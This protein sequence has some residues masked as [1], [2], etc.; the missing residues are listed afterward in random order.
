MKFDPTDYFL[1]SAGNR[2]DDERRICYVR[3]EE[4]CVTCETVTKW[5][6]DAFEAMGVKQKPSIIRESDKSTKGSGGSE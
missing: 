2:S 6:Y 3:H 4:F 1:E 5:I